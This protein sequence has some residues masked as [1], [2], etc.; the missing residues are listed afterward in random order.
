MTRPL[1]VILERHVAGGADR[2]VATIVPKLPPVPTVLFVNEGADD[3]VL[4][5]P[6]MPGH[7]TVR[8]YDWMTPATLAVWSHRARPGF[9]RHLRRAVAAALRYPLLGLLWLR[10]RS[11][12]R[13]LQPQAVWVNNGGYPGSDL[14]RMATLAAT[15]VPDCRTVHVVHSAAQP[16]RRPMRWPEHWLDGQVSRAAQLIAVSAAVANSLAAVRGFAGVTVVPNGLPPGPEPPPPPLGPTLAL[17]QVGYFDANKNQAMAIRA[18]GSLRRRGIRHIMLT[19]AGREVQPGLIAEL[20][21]LA[22]AEGVSDQVRY[23]GFVSDMETAYAACDAVVLTSFV[24]G[25]PLCV[26]E[27]MRAGRA[28]VATPAGGAPELVASGETGWVLPR[29]D[30]AELAAIWE[31]W[32]GNPAELASQGRAARRRF[33]ERHVV[34]AQAERI[35]A[36]LGL[37]D[38]RAHAGGPAHA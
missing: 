34:D 27:A 7:V 4:L 26:L 8:C 15:A 23:A 21:A 18:L 14:C 12:L 33:L 36:L 28:T 32:L 19:F 22:A 5:D 29:F 37:E 9:R 6:P 16:L 2:V 3:R 20:R 24:E 13:R 1:V 25:L 17:L 35:A 30:E 11:V 38:G 10:C 31:R